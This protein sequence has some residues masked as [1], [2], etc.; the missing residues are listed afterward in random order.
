MLTLSS[1]ILLY[2]IVVYFG[3]KNTYEFLIQQKRYKNC[4]LTAFYAIA[5]LAC[6]CRIIQYIFLV[7]VYLING[8]QNT[9][10]YVAFDIASSTLILA[11]GIVMVL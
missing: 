10:V 11:V 1:L 5:I 7:A 4:L 6:V 2:C 3:A 8:E 9:A